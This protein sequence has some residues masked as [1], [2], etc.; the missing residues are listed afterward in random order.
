M[1]KLAKAVNKQT[2]N[3]A[4]KVILSDSNIL[5]NETN[6]ILGLAVGNNANNLEQT[7]KRHSESTTSTAKWKHATPTTSL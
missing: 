5:S 6:K 7:Q 1:I 2:L 3:S 4:I